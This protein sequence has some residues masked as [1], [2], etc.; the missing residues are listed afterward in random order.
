[1]VQ[2]E[3]IQVVEETAE[4][5]KRS[6]SVVL[7]LYKGLTVAEMQDLRRQL[8][9]SGSEL[10]VVKN[11]LAKRALLDSGCEALD[12]VLSG[13]TAMAFGYSD[14]TAPAKICSKFAVTH[15]E[16]QVLGGLLDK[17]RIGLDK[18]QALAKLPSREELL[19][20]MAS[21]LMAPARQ[22]ATALKQA[23]SKVVYAMKDRASQL[24]PS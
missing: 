8:R 5:L 3:K 1:M 20:Q 14:A 2:P 18:I 11:R 24:E 19:S 21:T 6:Q 7:V 4:R 22:M 15:D 9:E 13:P 23:M 12:E 16:L 10:K 17:R